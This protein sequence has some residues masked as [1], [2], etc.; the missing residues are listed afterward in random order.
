M[1]VNWLEVHVILNKFVFL[2]D[3]NYSFWNLLFVENY[4]DKSF[5]KIKIINKDLRWEKY[6]HFDV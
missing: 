2:M 3:D 5:Y 6:H 1:G 4:H